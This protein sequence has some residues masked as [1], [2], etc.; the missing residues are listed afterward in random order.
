M[1][2][3]ALPEPGDEVLDDVRVIKNGQGLPVPDPGR[4]GLLRGSAEDLSPHHIAEAARQALDHRREGGISWLW[5]RRHSGDGAAY[6]TPGTSGP[7]A[8]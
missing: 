1:G 6:D 5:K 2:Q 3:P 7:G 4:A 8:P